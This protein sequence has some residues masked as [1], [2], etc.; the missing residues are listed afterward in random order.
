MEN[1]PAIVQKAKEYVQNL[2][3]SKAP[4]VNVYHDLS[5][6]LDVVEHVEKIGLKSDIDQTGLEILLLAAWFHDAGYVETV[7]DHE[8]IGCR[9]AAE[10]LD[11]ENYPADR[12][13]KVLACIMATK[14]P[15]QPKNLLEEIICDADMAHLGDKQY[16]QRSELLRLELEQ[17]GERKEN[18]TGWM[19]K[20]I[21]FLIAHRFFTPYARKKYQEQKNLNLL[22]MEKK[23]KKQKKKDAKSKG[24]AK[25]SKG[26]D[27][28]IETMFR[29]TIR[30]HVEF[31]SMADSK[32]NIMI[33]V[34]TLILTA[35]V[36]VLIRKLDSNPHLIVPT[37]V[38]TLNSIVTLI[39]AIL[40]TKPK[41]TEGKFS[42][43]DIKQKRANLLFFGNFYNMN[44]EDFKWGMEEMM[45]DKDFLYDSMIKDFYFL[46]QALG[47]KYKYLNICYNIF[48][49]GFI[50]SIIV[51][52]IVVL[53]Y[54]DS[55]QL[56]D[57]LY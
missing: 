39:F 6:T 47:R 36:V 4:A 22:E 16:L 52:G 26:T 25:G 56:Q 21:D 37:A 23:L 18:E 41:I 14:C 15:H 5:H 42:K 54:P 12:K 50:L 11:G 43:E 49:Y 35:I 19:Q 46:G 38:L 51:F 40:A 20:N 1:H 8:E 29:N 24:K 27:R 32:A 53:M 31:S 10:F 55:T 44:L 33:S 2:F 57:L 13:E 30:T 28:G 7:E 34:N 45:F 3:K 9:I 48:M 17:R